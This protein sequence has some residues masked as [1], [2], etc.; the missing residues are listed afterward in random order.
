MCYRH[1]VLCLEGTKDENI[2]EQP[3]LEPSV[4]DDVNSN[5]VELPGNH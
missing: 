3:Q 2:Y 4:N 5:T 1:L